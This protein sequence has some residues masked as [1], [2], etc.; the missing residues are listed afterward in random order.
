[1]AA[2]ELLAVFSR[3]VGGILAHRF[4]SPKLYWALLFIGYSSI[5]ALPLLSLVSLWPQVILLYYVERFGKGVRTPIRD[6]IL[7][8]VSEGIGKGKGFGLH[9]LLDQI[10]AILGPAIISSTIFLGG[11]LI[12]SYRLAFASLLVPGLLAPLT[13][14]VAHRLYPSPKAS[15]KKPKT[16]RFSSG[17]K[18]YLFFS[19]LTGIGLIHWAIIS[20]YLQGNVMRGVLVPAEVPLIYLVAML[21]DALSAIPFGMLFDRLGRRI[22]PLQPILTFTITPL[23]FIYGGKIGLYLASILWGLAVGSSETILRAAVA[24]YVQYDLRALGYGAFSTVFHASM[25]LGAGIYSYL[26]Q[27]GLTSW[28]I[29]ISIGFEAAALIIGLVDYLSITLTSRT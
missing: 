6:T 24:D 26:Y 19:S 7:S 1:M 9:E 3:M 12:Q 10:G 5:L 20:H 4:P 15:Q 11:D 2:G 23:L 25:V 18:K 28:I 13:L 21:S 14:L 27:L 17:F 8:E 22:L 16:W 29:M